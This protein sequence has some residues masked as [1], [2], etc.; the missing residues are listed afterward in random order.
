[1]LENLVYI[2][3]IYIGLAL[4]SLLAWKIR[5]WDECKGSICIFR[6]FYRVVTILLII[7]FFAV[8]LRTLDVFFIASAF[9]LILIVDFT[10]LRKYARSKVDFVKVSI[11]QRIYD[12]ID[13]LAKFKTIK[14]KFRL[15]YVILSFIFLSGL[16]FWMKP[17][18]RTRSLLSVVQHSHL[19]KITSMLLN[20]FKFKINDIAMNSLCAFFSLVFGINQYTILHLFGGFNFAVLFIGISLLTYRLTGEIYSVI[21]SASLFSFLFGR[22]NFILNPVEGSSL[23]LGI[24]W[25]FFVLIFWKDMKLYEKILSLFVL[26]LIDFFVGFMAVIL[27]PLSELVELIFK[28]PKLIKVLMTFLILVCLFGFEIYLRTNPELSVKIYALFYSP[29]LVVPPVSIMRFLIFTL[30]LILI[31]GFKTSIFHGIFSLLLLILTIAC[32]LS[33]F[34]FVSPEQ[35]YPFVVLILFVWSAVLVHKIFGKRKYLYNALVLIVALV[36]ISSAFFYEGSEVDS[37]IEPDEF[38]EVISKIQRE[39]TPF[40]FAVVS[41]YG[42][43]AMVENWAYFMDWDYFL[44]TY[45]FIDD[46]KKI[47]DVVYVIVPK[48][49][50]IDKIHSSFVPQIDN[51]SAL[52]DSACLNYLYASSEI[53]FE[54]SYIKVYKLKKLK[55]A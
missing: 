22:F 9:V 18:I 34:S 40:E 32:E 5:F 19:V 51:L 1:M 24:S 53:Y 11:N 35:F 4:I 54:G 46:D 8:W 16:L 7:L 37:R 29:E 50:S 41:H 44:K 36:V 12:F 28:N 55:S 21:L 13:G 48:E 20:D 17:A 3:K 26:F 38:V 27:I 49:S 2:F 47:Y 15:E 30:F 42:T 39:E 23:L 45:I 6:Y 43:R 31:F 25:L 52:L 33:I 10:I 14:L